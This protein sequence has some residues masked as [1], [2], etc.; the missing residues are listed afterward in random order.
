MTRAVIQVEDLGKEYVIGQREKRNE[1][2]REMLTSALA[3]P[4][5]RFQ[6]LGGTVTAEERFWALKDVSL[7]VNEGEVVGIIG[8]NGAGKSTLLKILSR[9]TAP[10]EGKVRI[11]GRVASL[12]EVGTGFHPELT[13]RENIDL[14]GAILGMN[15]REI[16]RKFDEIVAFAEVEKFLD[17]PVKHYS[18]GMYVRLAFAVAAHL[19]PDILLIDEVLAVGDAGFQKKCLNKMGEVSGQ[20]RTVL[21]VSHNLQA[22][23]NFCR[24]GIMLDRG[25]LVLNGSIDD[26]IS[27]YL[28]SI[29]SQMSLRAAGLDNRLNRTT[30]ELRFTKVSCRNDSGQTDWQVRH[31]GTV[32]ICFGYEALQTVPHLMFLI[33]LRSAASD[34]PLTVIHEVVSEAPVNR[35]HKGTIEVVFPNVPLR[36]NEISLYVALGRADARIFYDVIDKN[37]DLPFLRVTGQSTDIYDNMGTVSIPYR[38][39]ASA[40]SI[41]TTGQTTLSSLNGVDRERSD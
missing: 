22:I 24:C 1:T 11:L 17:T 20:G 31:G 23:R 40:D 38:L 16:Q 30:G 41:D 8:R 25:R 10:T 12:L 27:R 7:E 28:R 32:K 37:V 36:P 2:F 21:F 13:G 4:F 6:K 9:I 34:D 33:Q 15:R 39:S 3:S 35:G 5:R 19:D 14:N 18:S 29:P 26:C